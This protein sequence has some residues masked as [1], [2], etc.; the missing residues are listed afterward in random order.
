[1]SV[2]LDDDLADDIS[3][4]LSA[5][6]SEASWT[7]RKAQL[8]AELVG[9]LADRKYI[10][11]TGCPHRYG[12]S[13]VGESYLLDVPLYQQGA[14]KPFRGKRVRFVCVRSGR[15]K[16][17]YMAGIVGDTPQELIVSK[18]I[19]DY[20]FPKQ[21]LK[22]NPLYK[23]RR[24]LVIQPE[25]TTRI[26]AQK[27]PDGCVDLEQWDS[28]LF[29]GRDGLPKC[30]FRHNPDGT[31]TGTWFGWRGGRTHETLRDSVKRLTKGGL[32]VAPE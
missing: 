10:S 16:R 13:R 6:A 21:A 25:K 30:K 15:Y 24:Y 1:M 19:Y 17:G 32:P 29:D 7:K 11:F 4:I 9:L 20:S 18:L 23:S 14:L 3:V 12:I 26:E 2:M 8:K 22:Y 31:V 5:M 28:I 27:E